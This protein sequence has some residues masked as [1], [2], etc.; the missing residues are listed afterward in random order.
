MDGY[1]T[2]NVIGN[3]IVG[4]ALIDLDLGFFAAPATSAQE[5]SN[6]QGTDTEAFNGFLNESSFTASTSIPSI[7]SSTI[8]SN[9]YIGG[10]DTCNYI[11]QATDETINYIS[12]ATQMVS[13]EN[14]CQ[15][16]NAPDTSTKPDNSPRKRRHSSSDSNGS[17]VST[18]PKK[19]KTTLWRHQQKADL[20]ENE[21]KIFKIK[22][23]IEKLKSETHEKTIYLAGLQK[24]PKP[25]KP[26]YSAF[27]ENYPYIMI[28]EN[29]ADEK[30]TSLKNM[31]NGTKSKKIQQ[32]GTYIKEQKELLKLME[33][34]LNLRK[35]L[36]Q[37][38]DEQ[39]SMCMHG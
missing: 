24:Q 28:V 34:L 7:E 15:T 35:S 36:N 27:F 33:K 12:S 11:L 17:D 1:L 18:S 22:K 3:D 13:P 16:L 32:I 29:K 26:S 19:S 14:C 9:S 6:Q 37:V 10:H 21:S 39:I 20:N 5:N 2:N 31:E 23:E 38:M 30:E 25:T 8:K 4:Q